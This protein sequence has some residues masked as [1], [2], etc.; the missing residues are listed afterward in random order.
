MNI[1]ISFLNERFMLLDM[2]LSLLPHPRFMKLSLTEM[3]ICFLVM[4]SKRGIA[5]LH[6]GSFALSKL[7]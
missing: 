5:F 3:M 6:F 4:T 1:Q 2:T 7:R